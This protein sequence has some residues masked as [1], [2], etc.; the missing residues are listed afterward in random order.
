[1]N[2]RFSM[3]GVFGL[4]ALVFL[5]LAPVTYAQQ[6]FTSH[7]TSLR[8]GPNHGYPQ[9]AWVGSGAGVYVN[10]CVDGYYWCDVTKGGV[11]GWVSAR[12]LTY[13]HQSRRVMI[14]GNGVTFGTPLVAF[15]LGSYW[16]N[17]YRDR[18]WY[19]HHSHWNSWHPG[20]VAPR[21]W[22]GHSHARSHVHPRAHFDS[23]PRVHVTPHVVHP[24]YT[25]RVQPQR[26]EVRREHRHEHTRHNNYRQHAQP[27]QRH[28]VQR[29]AGQ[30][31]FI[32][33]R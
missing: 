29:G 8:A 6:A 10:G 4:F 21:H 3:A 22:H 30:A 13:A 19:Q 26:N 24:G 17:H 23:A 7:R 2:N 12:H 28:D 18:A 25:Y 9:V 27:H 32:A 15:T 11:R 33:P 5:L 16:D 1:M 20:T 14:Y 31:V